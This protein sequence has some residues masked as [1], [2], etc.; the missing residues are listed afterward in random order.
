MVFVGVFGLFAFVTGGMIAIF[1]GKS[2]G[3]LLGGTKWMTGNLLDSVSLTQF[4][5]SFTGGSVQR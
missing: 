2:N 4:K 1:K 5:E 3:E